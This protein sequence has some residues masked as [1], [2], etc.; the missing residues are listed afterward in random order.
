MVFRI[1]CLEPGIYFT[2]FCLK[3]GIFTRANVLN[4][5]SI[6]V[7]LYKFCH[8][9]NFC[10]SFLEVLTSVDFGIHTKLNSYLIMLTTIVLTGYQKSD[11]L[12]LNRFRIWAV[13]LT[14]E[15]YEGCKRALFTITQQEQEELILAKEAEKAENDP[16][17]AGDGSSYWKKCN[18]GKVPDG[19]NKSS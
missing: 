8:K 14:P 19:K 5:I 10:K 15:I 12:V 6:Y 11:I 17:Y 1:F 13:Q 9:L 18:K 4:R 2:P 16:M 3:Q 7:C